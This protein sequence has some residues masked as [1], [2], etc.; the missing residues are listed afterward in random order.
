MTSRLK[1]ALD[2]PTPPPMTEEQRLKLAVEARL[3]RAGVDKQR[4]A[5]EAITPSDLRIMVR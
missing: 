5:I 4:R 1:L 2:L 3:W